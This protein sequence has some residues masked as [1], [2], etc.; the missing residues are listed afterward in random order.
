MQIRPAVSSDLDQLCDIDGTITSPNYLHVEKTGEGFAQS[1]KLDERPLRAKLIEP[2]T[3]DD[4]T[5]F[6]MKQIVNAIEEGLALVAEH[7]QIVVASLIAQHQP[8]NSTFR[9]IDLRVDHDH[10]RQGVGSALLF[11]AIQ[12][13]R[14]LGLRA[15]AAQTKTSNVPAANF[16][17]KRGFDLAGLDTQL[18]SNHDLV[19]ETVTLFWYAALT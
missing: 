3:L 18:H 12:Q 6:T 9:L 13:A 17:V 4:E 7:E 11:Q 5:R 15:V 1:W 10:R 19:K 8:A 2:N 16:L 14:E